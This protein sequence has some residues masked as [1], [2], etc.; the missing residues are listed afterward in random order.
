MTGQHLTLE[1]AD[2]PTAAA[3]TTGTNRPVCRQPSGDDGKKI[4][5]VDALD[6]GWK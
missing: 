1:L 2:D 4:L 3:P 6:D 5:Q